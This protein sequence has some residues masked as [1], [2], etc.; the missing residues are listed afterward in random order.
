MDKNWNIKI[1]DFG[2][3]CAKGHASGGEQV[4][5]LWT[6]PE[7]LQQEQNCYSDKSDVYRYEEEQK[8]E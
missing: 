3:S 1:A 4:S 6:A 5:L 2:L 8:D 7:V